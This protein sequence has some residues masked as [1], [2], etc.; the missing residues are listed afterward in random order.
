M[1]RRW[2][3]RKAEPRTQYPE[4]GRQDPKKQIRVS[5]SKERPVS[6]NGS[7]P[8]PVGR[9]RPPIEIPVDKDIHAFAGGGHENSAHTGKWSEG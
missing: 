2:N 7:N 3:F 5:G 9:F 4:P 1:S 6:R 8:L